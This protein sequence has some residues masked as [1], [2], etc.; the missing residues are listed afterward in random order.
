MNMTPFLLSVS[1][2]F[3]CAGI[4]LLPDGFLAV[5]GRRTKDRGGFGE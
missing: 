4:G 3:V 5:Y 2:V 1:A